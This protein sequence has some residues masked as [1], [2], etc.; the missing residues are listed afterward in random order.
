MSFLRQQYVSIYNL[1]ML[2]FLDETGADCRNAT[3]KYGYSMR[4]MPL[5][6]QQFLVR[7]ERV[8]AL[9]IIF[10]QWPIRCEGCARNTF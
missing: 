7:G 3:R 4:G 5:V 8:S 10:S 2:V 6:S 1:E 9:A